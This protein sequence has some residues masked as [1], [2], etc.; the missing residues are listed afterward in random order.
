MVTLAKMVVNVLL[1]AIHILVFVMLVTQEPIVK[2]V[3]YFS[4]IIYV[5]CYQHGK[6]DGEGI[7]SSLHH[8]CGSQMLR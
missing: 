5:S 7:Q 3:S 1:I 6:K 2:M 8:V 4:M